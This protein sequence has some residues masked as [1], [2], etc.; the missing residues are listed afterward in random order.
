M[1]R[2]AT[3][4]VAL[5]MLMTMGACVP[6]AIKGQKP[7]HTPISLLFYPGGVSLDDLVIIDGVN[8]FG[9]IET[10]PNEPLDDLKFTLKSG[11][12]FIAE[13][14][15]IGTNKADQQQC[16]EYDVYRSDDEDLLPERTVFYR[17]R[18]L[19]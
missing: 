4:L 12:I 14:T 2:L 10:I 8:Y 16:E 6:T 3:G 9:K 11:A 18:W 5:F 13:C 7:D 17:P 15:A 19:K 1:I